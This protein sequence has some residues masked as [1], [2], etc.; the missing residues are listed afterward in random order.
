M[1][2]E[3]INIDDKKLTIEIFYD[4]ELCELLIKKKLEKN[5]YKKIQFLNT[6]IQN[7]RLM[8]ILYSNIKKTCYT[9]KNIIQVFIEDDDFNICSC[10][11]LADSFIQLFD[12]YNYD[13][14][15]M[16]IDYI[17]NIYIIKSQYLE[18]DIVN[19]VNYNKKEKELLNLTYLLIN[20]FEKK[21]RVSRYHKYKTQIINNIVYLLDIGIINMYEE[22]HLRLLDLR[23]IK[24]RISTGGINNIDYFLLIDESKEI[25]KRELYLKQKTDSIYPCVDVFIDYLVN[26][27]TLLGSVKKNDIYN[28]IYVFKKNNNFIYKNTSNFITFSKLVMQQSLEN[29]PL[30][31]IDYTNFYIELCFKFKKNNYLNRISNKTYI[32]TLLETAHKISRTEHFIYIYLANLCKT[33]SYINNRC[34]ILN[35]VDSN[36]IKKFS[37]SLLDNFKYFH[38]HF[39]ISSVKCDFNYFID[40]LSTISITILVSFELRNIYIENLFYMLEKIFSEE[41]LFLFDHSNADKINNSILRLFSSSYNSV[42]NYFSYDVAVFNNTIWNKYI[43]H[44]THK[45]FLILNFYE[46]I[47]KQLEFN[48]SNNHS[49][50]PI[51]SNIIEVPVSI[52]STH[53]VMDKYIIYRCLMDKHINPFNRN[54]LTITEL[55]SHNN[56]LNS[57]NIIKKKN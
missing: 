7:K 9:T 40:F 54:K 32:E 47:Q 31:V 21:F 8:N 46:T 48:K 30:F 1:S 41:H 19:D 39:Y 35:E 51:C 50:D 11:H 33:I 55:Q 24:D 15:F 36:I 57:S 53:V 18:I 25:F 34:Q 16:I 17:T 42:L 14:F 23:D 43:E 10:S 22:L 4:R 37:Y 52:P 56:T 3:I 26:R 45:N 20:I 28:I 27:V 13:Y 38:E 29:S 6:C 5:I 2:L 44:F 12:N 49:I